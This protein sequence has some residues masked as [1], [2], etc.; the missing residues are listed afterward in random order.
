MTER[1]RSRL[2]RADRPARSFGSYLRPDFVAIGL[3]VVAV[4]VIGLVILQEPARVGS[5]TLSNPSQYDVVVDVT[6][7]DR[8]SWL[9]LAV[10]DVGTTREYQEVLDQG[11]TWVFRFRAQGADGGETAVSRKDLVAAG[12]KYTIP[13]DV[14]QRLQAAGAPA[15][16]CL[17]ATCRAQG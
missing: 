8:A 2:S 1:T 5:L 12:W 16:A 9:P 3:A 11:D 7:K 13:N 14:I 15:G 10:V 4:M 6:S 17:S